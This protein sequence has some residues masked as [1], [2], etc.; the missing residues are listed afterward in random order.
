MVGI[1]K[2]KNLINKL[3]V[4][5]IPYLIFI[6]TFTPFLPEDFLNIINKILYFGK[7]ETWT[8]LEN[9]FT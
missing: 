1:L 3:L 2:K 8:F 5:T 7:S 4:L 6:I 9:Y